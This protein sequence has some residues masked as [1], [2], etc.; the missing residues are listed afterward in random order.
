M[1]K[2]TSAKKPVKKAS[3]TAA[4]KDSKMGGCCGNCS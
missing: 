4:K 3:A 2:K 1:A